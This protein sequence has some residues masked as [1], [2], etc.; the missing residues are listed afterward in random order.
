M[1]FSELVLVPIV[2]LV[3]CG[4]SPTVTAPTPT[5]PVASP[6]LPSATGTSP[7]PSLIGTVVE[8]TPQGERPVGGA[9][10][11]G[12][13]FP[14]SVL[15]QVRTDELGRFELPGLVPGA[16]LQV[17]AFKDGYFQQCAVEI[18]VGETAQ[19]ELPLVADA[20]LSSSK[21]FV[22]PSPSES[23]IVTGVVYE[24]TTQGRRAVAHR[25]VFYDFGLD[26]AAGTRTD[27]QGRFLLCGL[28]RTRTVSIVEAVG[29]AFATVPPGGDADIEIEAK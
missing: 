19:L 28:P 2:F 21:D 16:S 12:Q 26:P 18:R 7:A 1:R 17:M 24:R 15:A 23:R 6:A 5:R 27:D 8:R 20:N 10:V 4:G 11:W 3:G 29:L 13:L 22:P 25:P 14:G 9:F